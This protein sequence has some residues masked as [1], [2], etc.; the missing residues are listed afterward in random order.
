MLAVSACGRTPYV[1]PFDVVPNEA[2]S[3]VAVYISN[4]GWHTGIIIPAREISTRLPGLLDRFGQ[5]PYFEFGW[6]DASYYQAR[7]VT[8]GLMVKA[9]FWPT[10][11]VIQVV[12][13][14]ED[15]AKYFPDSEIIKMEVEKQALDNLITFITL[16]FDR[17]SAGHIQASGPGIYG[18]SEFYKAE[19]KYYLT[20]T[21]NTWTAKGM[22]SMGMDI[23]VLCKLT[24]GSIMR[25][26]RHAGY[27]AQSSAQ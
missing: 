5:V 25:Y 19:G 22:K 6:G 9:V 1:V 27:A 26:L 4:H 16:S 17:D 14:P 15:P 11:S 8:S 21:C 13:I 7:K 24:S 3:R 20:N 18:D 12:A 23:S 10:D 2:A